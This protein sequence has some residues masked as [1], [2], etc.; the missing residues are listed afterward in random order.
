[1]LDPKNLA[2]GDVL[3][4]LETTRLNQDP[5]TTIWTKGKRYRVGGISPDT[6][7]PELTKFDIEDDKKRMG[8]QTIKEV[9]MLFRNITAEQIARRKS[10]A[11]GSAAR[12]LIAYI[13]ESGQRGYERKFVEGQAHQ[14]GLMAALVIPCELHDQIV[15]Q[16]RPGFERF[17]NAAPD[18]ARLHITD[19]WRRGNEAWAAVA[20]VVREEF[21][22]LIRAREIPIIYDARRVATARTRHAMH[23]A[24]E[25]RLRRL[26]SVPA[27][28]PEYVDEAQMDHRLLEGLSWK[29]KWLAGETDYDNL[30]LRFDGLQPDQATQ[31]AEIIKSLTPSTF[32]QGASSEKLTCTSNIQFPLDAVTLNTPSIVGKEAPMILAIDM[33]ANSLNNHLQKLPADAPL[34][35]KSSTIGWALADRAL[36]PD[37]VDFSDIL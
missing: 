32:A 18:G 4:A 35:I 30:D 13:D 21:F 16:F 14:L 26:P 6:G 1:M 36:V 33:V 17:R 31:Y 10:E 29:L 24:Q 27:D 5:H 7:A 3:E 9:G 34:N 2:T 25:E 8:V 19:A 28:I 23:V 37:D 22:N 11:A 20:E 12:R 15:E